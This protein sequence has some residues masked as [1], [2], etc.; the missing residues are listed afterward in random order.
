MRTGDL[1]GVGLGLGGAKAFVEVEFAGA[2]V[3]VEAVGGVGGLLYLK[4]RQTRPDGVDGA[5]IDEDHVA[6][7]DG[8]PLE[9]IFEG[10]VGGGGAQDSGVTPGLEAEGHAGA[11]LGF[12]DV[13]ALGLAAGLTYLLRASVVGVYLHGELLRRKEDF[14]QQREVGGG[15]VTPRMALGSC[16]AIA[17]ARVLPASGPVSMMQAGPVSQASPMAMSAEAC[18]YHGARPCLPPYAFAEDRGA[19]GRARGLTRRLGTC[20]SP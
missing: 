11:G 10:V 3:V 4:Q 7:G 18:G 6:D 5:G 14:E 19:D 1:A 16:E 9:Q 15:G 17:S 2:A 8:Q 20:S 12:E 13:P